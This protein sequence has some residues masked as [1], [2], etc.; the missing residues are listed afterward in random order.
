MNE[1]FLESG[2]FKV[3]VANHAVVDIM[4]H[5]ILACKVRDENTANYIML[6]A[7]NEYG[8]IVNITVDRI[9]TAR[10]DYTFLDDIP[11]T[12]HQVD[13]IKNKVN[14]HLPTL[15]LLY[16]DERNF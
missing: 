8:E 6:I 12:K 2:M 10:K 7:T 9:E 1:Y 5:K 14:I 15:K 11:L 16:K 13:T 4:Y 3:V